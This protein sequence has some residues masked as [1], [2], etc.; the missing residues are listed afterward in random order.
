MFLFF[1]GE[2]SSVSESI[3]T[4]VRE[5]LS[6]RLEEERFIL[7]EGDKGIEEVSG[8]EGRELFFNVM[9]L[10]F[11]LNDPG[12]KGSSSPTRVCWLDCGSTFSSQPW[13]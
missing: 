9:R 1:L 11:A 10:T 12:P 5:P 6:E 13:D 8:R 2:P 4:S 3:S 7:L